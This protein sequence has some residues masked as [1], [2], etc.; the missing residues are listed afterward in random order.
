MKTIRALFCVFLAAACSAQAALKF[1]L[2]GSPGSQTVTVEAS[3]STPATNGI[4]VPLDSAWSGYGNYWLNTLDSEFF[5]LSNG[6]VLTNT[7]NGHVQN[8]RN[9]W[10]DDGLAGDGFGFGLQSALQGHPSATYVLSGTATFQIAPGLDFD[11]LFAGAG[12]F[13]TTNSKNPLGPGPIV[14]VVNTSAPPAEI[15]VT[16]SAT[17]FVGK[18]MVKVQVWVHNHGGQLAENVPVTLNP[19]GRRIS[20][21]SPEQSL[22]KVFGHINPG[23][24]KELT[25]RLIDTYDAQVERAFDLIASSSFDDANLQNNTGSVA[26]QSFVGDPLLGNVINATYAPTPPL[27]DPLLPGQVWTLPLNATSSGENKTTVL[28]VTPPA[29][30]RV[31]GVER[32]APGLEPPGFNV[33]HVEGGQFW[34]VT[35]PSAPAGTVWPLNIHFTGQPGAAGLIT[36][37]IAPGTPFEEVKTQPVTFSSSIAATEVKCSLYDDVNGNEVQDTGEIPL[38]NWPFIIV[39]AG[40]TFAGTTDCYGECVLYLPAGSATLTNVGTSETYFFTVPS[41]GPFFEDFGAANTGPELK[42]EFLWSS[43]DPDEQF[44]HSGEAVPPATLKVQNLSSQAAT[45]VD[46]VVYFHDYP[47][48][49]DDDGFAEIENPYTAERTEFSS[50]FT[51]PLVPAGGEVILSV[52]LHKRM[53][54]QLAAAGLFGKEIHVRALL[55]D[56]DDA[57]SANNEDTIHV[58]LVQCGVLLSGFEPEAPLTGPVAAGTP[59]EFTATLTGTGAQVPTLVRFETGPGARLISLQPEAAVPALVFDHVS[60]GLIWEVTIPPVSQGAEVSITGLIV[61]AA[62]QT[63]TST[64]TVEP[65]DPGADERDLSFTVTGDATPT[66]LVSGQAGYDANSS[67]TLTAGERALPGWVVH[68]L[69]GGSNVLHLLTDRAGA[70]GVFVAAGGGPGNAT[71]AGGGGAPGSPV[72]FNPVPGPDIDLDLPVGPLEL[73]GRAYVDVNHDFAYTPGTDVPMP[74]LTAYLGLSSATGQPTTTD[75]DGRYLFTLP[76]DTPGFIFNPADTGGIT[77]AHV[78]GLDE[79]AGIVCRRPALQ[80]HYIPDFTAGIVPLVSTPLNALDFALGIHHNLIA[81]DLP[82]PGG[83]VRKMRW[84]KALGPDFIPEYAFTLAGGV[85]WLE[86]TQGRTSDDD[87]YYADLP[88]APDGRLFVRLRYHTGP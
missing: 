65:D 15:S 29:G 24:T 19:K 44:V 18:G 73:S 67:G 33:I 85:V 11:E 9:L 82:P 69:T 40:Q 71:P 80:V 10:F 88:E 32:D 22:T 16:L 81:L 23:E 66:V 20:L 2:T 56:Y 59:V 57:N 8:V 13:S 12:V 28:H 75:A 31:H 84:P 58:T 64:C 21:D 26:I 17:T 54:A 36:T 4:N 63:A 3:G 74:G 47:D 27:L 25:F 5:T 86:I 50:Y 76:P 6:I 49:D 30:I 79:P 72:G 61:P 52:P 37:V 78:V 45:N 46:V 14:Q 48:D 7:Q 38:G 51:V 70:F 68:L 41:G 60:A 53:E 1:K 34:V 35:I 42:V 55:E 62:N 39:D 43:G 77:R 83:G 87:Y